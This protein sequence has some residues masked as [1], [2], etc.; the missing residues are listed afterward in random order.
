MISRMLLPIL[1][2]VLLNLGMAH[3]ETITLTEKN[4]VVFRG[5]VSEL[6]V[7]KV[8]AELIEKA[9]AGKPLYLVL[10]TPGGSVDAGN[11]LIT[12]VK[13]LGVKVHTVTIFAASMGF[14]IVQSLDD[15]LIIPNG[16]LMSHRANAGMRGEIPGEFLK[17]LVFLLRGLNAMDA[18]AAKRMGL[19][20]EV[21]QDWIRDEYWVEGSD[22]IHDK[23][24]DRVVH[25]KCGEGLQGTETLTM[26]TIF[27][28]VN[29][30]MS[31]C[32]L[33]T[34]PLGIDVSDVKEEKPSVDAYVR[35]LFSNRFEFVNKYIKTNEYQKFQ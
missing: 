1:G 34:G 20:T 8:Q 16:V 18:T 5:V 30:T 28:A 11:M 7:S 35:T 17:R 25:V 4:S 12:T 26:N 6:S 15:R 14:H 10:D 27:G 21:Y 3:A 22:A 31:K 2:M 33:I 32:P 9:K 23:A 29:F 19:K 13:G 24:A